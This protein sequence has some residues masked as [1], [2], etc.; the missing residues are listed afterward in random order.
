[1]RLNIALYV[2]WLSCFFFK[3]LKR[4]QYRLYVKRVTNASGGRFRHV[5]ETECS[6]MFENSSLYIKLCQLGASHSSLA[7]IMAVVLTM[8]ESNEEGTRSKTAE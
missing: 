5:T 3:E 8:A 7:V 1:M 4:P 2:Y 6:S